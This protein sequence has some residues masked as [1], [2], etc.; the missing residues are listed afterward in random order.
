MR[1]FYKVGDQFIKAYDMG[2][3]WQLVDAN[4][5]ERWY[6]KWQANEYASLTRAYFSM[7]GCF[8]DESKLILCEK[9]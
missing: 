8:F 4:G 3:D 9:G 6:S 2:D 7:L 5:V 1:A